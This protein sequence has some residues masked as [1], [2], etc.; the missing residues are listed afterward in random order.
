MELASIPG[1]VHVELLR[2]ARADV[3]SRPDLL[4]EVPHGA[5][6]RAHYDDYRAQMTGPLPEEL[7]EFFFVNTDVGAYAYGRATAERVLRADPTRTALVVRCLIPRTFIDCNRVLGDAT[8]GMTAAIPPYVT[9]AAD[10]EALCA[11]YDAYV[12]TVRAAF[13][14]VCGAGGYAL[15]PHT[16][17]PRTMGIERIDD[18][19][20]KNL[21]WACEGDREA[22]WP[23]RPELDLITRDDAGR[24]LCPEHAVEMA[25]AAFAAAGLTA[26]TNETY[27]LSEAS[28][29]Y[30][31][32]VTYPGR[33]LCLEVRRDLL[34]DEWRALREMSISPAKV[35]RVA[36]ALAVVVLGMTTPRAP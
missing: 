36:E 27:R 14:L 34:V 1:V 15:V 11:R 25:L 13:A 29:G 23:L 18:D 21:R 5:D 20:V 6:E 10:R 7:E 19:I 2:G 33:V 31:W 32:A 17:G 28:L 4:V 22:S 8:G 30:E 12:A 3:A 35:A 16:Y 9:S 26:R 24:E